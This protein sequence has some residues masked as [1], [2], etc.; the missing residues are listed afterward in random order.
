MFS[1]VTD[2]ES[3]AHKVSCCKFTVTLA[4]KRTVLWLFFGVI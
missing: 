1:Y 3:A 4:P 2:K